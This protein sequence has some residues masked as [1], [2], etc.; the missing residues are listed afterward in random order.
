MGE[1]I[2]RRKYGSI[3]HLSTSKLE[4]Q[5]DKKIEMGQELILTK[6]A[7]DWKDLIVV[8]E[9]I[10]GSNVGVVKKN[11][12]LKA[13]SRAGYD[14]F[15]SP[16]L[17]HHLFGEYV[18]KNNNLFEWLPEGWRVSGEW[19][20]KVH[21]TIYDISKESPFIAFDIFNSKND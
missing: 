4:Q 12:E 19:C 11:G 1:K 16:Y 8:T 13:I 6:K 3:P 18:G 7:R 14:V 15:T 5:A 10:D 9:K 20:I 21:G 2:I 17:Q